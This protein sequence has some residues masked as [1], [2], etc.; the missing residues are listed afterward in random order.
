LLI[1]HGLNDENVHF[2]HTSTLIESLVRN[3]KPHTVQVFPGERHGIR[4][5]AA[6]EY[7][8]SLI[9]HFLLVNL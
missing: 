9:F 4:D 5:P 1:I 3:G 8:D 7:L 2:I 6:N